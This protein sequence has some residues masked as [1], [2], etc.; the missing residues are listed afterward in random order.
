MMTKDE[1]ILDDLA[2]HLFIKIGRNIDDYIKLCRV[3]ELSP[4]D[5]MPK[6]MFLLIQLTAT[7]A[8]NEYFEVDEPSVIELLQIQLQKARA[9]LT[10]QED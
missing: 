1:Q 9:N 2:R 10:E 8:I 5:A 6:L 3:A 7:I 4:I